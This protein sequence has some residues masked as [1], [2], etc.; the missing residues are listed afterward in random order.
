MTSKPKAN[1]RLSGRMLPIMR[2]DAAGIDIGAEEISR[3]AEERSQPPALARSNVTGFD[4]AIGRRRR[5]I[6]APVNGRLG[7]VANIPAGSVVREGEKPAAV[8]P[9][10]ELRIVANFQPADALGRIQ[11]GQPARLRLDGFP[12]TK[13][14]SVSATVT[15]IASEVRG[16]QIRVELAVN[17][18][19]AAGGGSARRRKSSS[20]LFAASCAT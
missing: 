6:R 10:G 12:W 16:R 14:G 5:S 19:S 9:S 8:V 13:Y 4:P 1:P 7:E 20:G 17:P 15:R 18:N 3:R 2:A 11:P